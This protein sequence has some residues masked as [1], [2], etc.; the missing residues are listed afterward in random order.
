MRDD[1]RRLQHLD[2]LRGIAALIVVVFHYLSAF[3]PTLT[4]D[5][6][7]NPY[8]LSDT[9]LAVLFNGP[10]AVVVFF[11]L[12]GFVVSKAA[13]SHDPL[14]LT[15]VLRY[16]RLTIPMLFSVLIAWLLLTAFPIEATKLA[17][18][19]GTPWLSKTFNGEIPSLSQALG[20]STY[21][22]YLRGY[23]RFNNAIWTM[24]WELIGSVAIY[25]VYAFIP[26]AAYIS[27]AFIAVF[28]LLLWKGPPY[29]YEAFIF[30]ALMQ[31]AWTHNKMRSVAPKFALM[32]G[33]ILGS[34]S[35]GF[36]HRYGFDFLPWILRPGET[37]GMIYPIAAAL[38]LYGCLMS[39]PVS[40]LLQLSPVLFLGRISFGTYLI[41]VPVLYTVVMAVA[42][43]LWP[44][45]PITLSIGLLIFAALS[46]SLGWLMTLA[47][48]E[49]A[50][51]LL[52]SIRKL[53]RG[54]IGRFGR[55]PQIT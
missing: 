25:M 11:V 28:F 30:G 10:F 14:P 31:E 16:F 44:M 43:L 7:A 34:Q 8:W 54:A 33:L 15:I 47:V 49:P 32:T 26:R 45:S 42:V 51:R 53:S 19:T 5:Q 22:V 41:H 55:R 36:S 35:A 9:P 2:G 21:E 12:S 20:D 27:A 52:S 39:V 48:D 3:V 17:S 46:V 6:T 4:P 38:V 40:R 1:T 18:I 29:Y 13:H 37:E 50:L 24:R 23:S